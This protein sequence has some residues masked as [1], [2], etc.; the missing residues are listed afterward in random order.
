MF[1]YGF[2]LS[3]L[4]LYWQ[5]HVVIIFYFLLLCWGVD[6]IVLRFY[7]LFTGLLTVRSGMVGT[8]RC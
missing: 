3:L 7:S 2:V 5:L 4:V 8:W 6:C 1:V